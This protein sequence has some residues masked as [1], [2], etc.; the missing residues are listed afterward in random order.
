MKDLNARLRAAG[1][2][3]AAGSLLLIGLP[4]FAADAPAAATPKTDAAKKD[5][6]KKDEPVEQIIVTG[7]RI[8]RDS[9]TSASP[10]QV[11]TKEESVLAGLVTTT[12][13]LQGSTVSGGSNQI[14]NYFGGYVTD[15]GPGANTLSLRGLGATRTLILLNGRRLAPAGTRGS[16]GAADLNVLP[17][18]MVDR[19]EILK[20]GA[21]S[22]YGSDAVAGVVNIITRK[23]IRD[24]T[25]EATQMNT[26]DQGG[27]QTAISG[28]WGH[29]WGRFELSGSLEMN[30][31]SELS[32]GQRDWARCSTYELKDPTTGDYIPGGSVLDP[33][34]G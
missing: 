30:A 31:R 14:N 11:I 16:V 4:S 10:I 25:V 1:L 17:S 18:A 19:I 3:A 29:T 34:T 7:S 33:A 27:N 24:F 15:G 32:V 26:W 28:T 13:T 9:F 5:E 6:E 2:L 22:I 12:E 8:H 23:G 20:D 21:S